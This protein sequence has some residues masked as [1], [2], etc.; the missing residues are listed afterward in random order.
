MHKLFPVKIVSG[1][2]EPKIIN[3]KTLTNLILLFTKWFKLS[4]RKLV[5]ISQIR[6]EYVK[7]KLKEHI[8]D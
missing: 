7:K 2:L 8:I 3:N 6:Q 5:F 4:L 1:H